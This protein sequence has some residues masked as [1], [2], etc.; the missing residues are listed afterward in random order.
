MTPRGTH[1]WPDNFLTGL[2]VLAPAYFTY[3]I[4]RFVLGQIVRFFAPVFRVLEPHL[5][6]AWITLLIRAA[7]VVAFV[8]GVTVIGWATRILVFRR[9]FSAV[10]YRLR[11]LPMVGKLYS[12]MRDIAQAFSGEHKTAFNRVVLVEW[13]GKGRYAVGFVT[14]DG[15]GEVQAKTPEHVVNV[16]VPTTPNPTSGFLILTDREA[17]IPLDMSVEDGLKLVISGGVVGPPVQSP[18][19]PGPASASE[20]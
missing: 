10:E 2:I 18:S 15:K 3:L 7:A 20:T 19:K 4:V 1:R 12:A 14:Q 8:G 5:T 11:R 17:L 9:L 16:F 6:S 13:P